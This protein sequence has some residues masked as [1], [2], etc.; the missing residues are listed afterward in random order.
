[1]CIWKTAWDMATQKT[2]HCWQTNTI[3]HM[4]AYTI[5]RRRMQSIFGERERANWGKV[6]T[7]TCAA[8][9]VS[10]DSQSREAPPRSGLS[11]SLFEAYFR[12][13]MLTSVGCFGG[14]RPTRPVLEKQRCVELCCAASITNNR[15]SNTRS[16]VLLLWNFTFVRVFRIT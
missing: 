16:F 5:T 2:A 7:S 14:S 9:L 15:A 3:L 13:S 1:M 6:S 8:S 12:T 4:F 10:A 11:A